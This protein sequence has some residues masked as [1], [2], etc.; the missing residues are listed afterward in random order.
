MN[1][2]KTILNSFVF[3]GAWIIIPVLAEILPSLGSI[4]ML[5][6]RRIRGIAVPSRPSLYPEVSLIVPVY[7]SADTLSACIESIYNSTYP[8]ESIRVFLVNNRS[9]DESFSIFAQCQARFPDLRMQWMDAEQGKSRAMNLALYNSEGKYII[10]LDSDGVLE[11]TALA[12]MVNKFEAHPD[13]NCMTG[14]I[15]TRPEKIC[16]YRGLFSRLLRNLEFLEY[17]QAF[18]AGRSYASELNAVYTLSGAF[19]A[20]RKSSLLK[21]R[22]YNTDTVCEDTHI[23]FQMRELQNERV[24]ICENALFFVDPIE[25]VNKLYVQRQRWQRGSLEVARMFLN[26]DFRLGRVLKD[27]NVKTL[28][29]DHTFAFPRLIWYLALICMMCMQ[30]ST[31]VILWST[32]MI[33]ALYIAVGVFYFI[34][35]AIFLKMDPPLRRFYL[36]RWWCVPL[37]PFFNLAVFFIRV[38]GIINSIQTDSAWKQRDLSEEREAFSGVIKED[39]SRPLRALRRVRRMVNRT[40]GPAGTAEGYG[41]LWYLSVGTLTVLGLGL[42]LLVDWSK[43]AFHVEITEIVNTLQGPLEGTG[44]GMQNEVLRGFALPMGALAAFCVILA[45]ADAAVG[46]R[47]RGGGK[48]GVWRATHTF[49]V[50]CG[51]AVLLAGVVY[52]NHAYGLLDY[53]QTAG[54]ETTLY[55]DEYVDPRQVAVTAEGPARNLIYIYVESLETTYA[56]EEDGGR[57]EGVNYMPNL[58]R[59]AGEYLSFGDTDGVGGFHCTTGSTWTVGAL[60]STTCGVPFLQTS[61]S[62]EEIIATEEF[63]PGVKNLGDILEDN[64]YT[65]MF[66]CGSNTRFGRRDTFF[67]KHGNYRIFGDG[68]AKKLGYVPKDYSVNWGI[69]DKVLFDIAREELT[70]LAAEGKPFNF[71]MLTTDLHAPKGFDCKW[72]ADTYDTTTARAVDCN[73]RVVTEFVKWCQRQDFY[74]NTTIVVTGD[75]PR[76][77]GSLVDGV[78]YYDRTVYDCFINPA[79][80]WVRD[81]KSR[82]FTAMDMFPTILSALG[83]DIEGD[84]LGLGTDLFSN[85]DTLL[86][87]KGFDWLNREL[88]K[89]SDYYTEQFVNPPAAGTAASRSGE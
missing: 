86:E 79:K 82:S 28:L 38:A 24:E 10:N 12:N 7:N 60:V 57:Q 83:F 55:E 84:R 35:V 31:K 2:L 15:L 76:M 19:S 41:A 43:S 75:H 5:L 9:Q 30:Y 77:D 11:R 50:F 27:V 72:C 32:G 45:F 62:E 37:L 61:L 69:E 73:D 36:R 89:R 46:R 21:S 6:K 4:M 49:G 68:T 52:G 14:A 59:L 78:S 51:V 29:Y 85:T 48:R 39:A 66:L 8:R 25:S 47:L 42:V 1:F 22:M 53:Y 71:T 63:L 80:T 13:V 56:S 88:G 18:L 54:S 16:S 87:R 33:F 74:E 67:Q 64:G 20:F 40:P 65:Q 81:E 17:A 26:K 34:T 70:G 3:W 44:A 23:T 58:T